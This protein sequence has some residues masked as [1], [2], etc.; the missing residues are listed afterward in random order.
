MKI[1]RTKFLKSSFL[2]AEKDMGLIITEILKNERLKKLLAYTDKNP[3]DHNP[4]GEAETIKLF[5]KNIKMVPKVTINDKENNI[6]LIRFRN[7]VP[8]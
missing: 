1:D 4:L 5:G 3:L 6:L 2:S 8:N 7:F